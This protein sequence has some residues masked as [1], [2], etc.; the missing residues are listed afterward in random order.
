MCTNNTDEKIIEIVRSYIELYDLSPS[1]YM[2]ITTK[3]GI[4]LEMK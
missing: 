1:K 4:L 3:F 2:D